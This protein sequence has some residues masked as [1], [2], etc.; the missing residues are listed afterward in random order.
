[1]YD[2]ITQTVGSKIEINI[3]EEPDCAWVL[4]SGDLITVDKD[5][6]VLHSNQTSHSCATRTFLLSLNSTGSDQINIYYAKF[7]L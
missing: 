2:N 5:S 7:N 6:I 1:M 3:T 4:D